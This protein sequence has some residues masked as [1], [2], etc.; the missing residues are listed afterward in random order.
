[1]RTMVRSSSIFFSGDNVAL[2]GASAKGAEDGFAVFDAI[3]KEK[4][5]PGLEGRER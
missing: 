3:G 1:M 4:I 5:P 2:T